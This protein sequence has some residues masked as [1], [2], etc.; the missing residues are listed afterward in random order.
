MTT[1]DNDVIALPPES[2]SEPDTISRRRVYFCCLA[3]ISVMTAV[4]HFA[5]A[6][7]HFQE[8]WAF[9]VF[10]L[11]TA[12]LQLAWA[13]AI[14]VKPSKLLLAG[15][16]VVNAGIVVVYILTR[17]VGDMVGPTPHDVE[18]FG[19]GDGLCT[20][21]EALVA[22]ACVWLLVSQSDV[23][24]RRQQLFLAPAMTGA[25]GAL[26]LS[27]ALVDGGGEMVMSMGDD[28]P[29]AVTTGVHAASNSTSMNMAGSHKSAS[30]GSM[31]MAAVTSHV[32]KLPT[33][34]PAGDVTTLNPNAMHMAA[35]MKMAS[36]VACTATPTK[37]QQA[38][39]VSL[40]NQSWKDTQK[41]RSLAAAKAAGYVAIT[42]V[43]QRV[44]HYLNGW[45]LHDVLTGGKVLKP[46]EPQSLVYANTPHGAVLAASM[47]INAIGAPPQPGGCLTQWHVHTNLCLSGATVVGTTHTGCPA[48]SANDITPPMMHVWYVPIPGGP[49]AIDAPD[50][51]VVHAAEKVAAPKNGVA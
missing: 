38:A 8:Y 4:I 51:Q 29:A 17:T 42:P 39:T 11:V 6:G 7:E 20:V 19:F 40:V 46:S 43:G 41:F 3:I 5:V 22:V 12:W 30:A 27:V 15:G 16:A 35:G 37:A 28:A 47:Y 1:G 48:G 33:E 18:P 26:L 50:R 25:L 21:L 14:V 23:R 44:V 34:S 2:A 31:H 9:G 36:T 45:Y 10:M 24:V 49:N 32:I 13:V